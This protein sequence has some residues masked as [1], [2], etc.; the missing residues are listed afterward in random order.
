MVAVRSTI[1]PLNNR[2]TARQERIPDS[3]V[4]PHLA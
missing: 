4:I 2:S 3:H 1:I